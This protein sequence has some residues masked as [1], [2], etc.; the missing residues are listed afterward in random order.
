MR[1]CRPRSV[2]CRKELCAEMGRG[3]QSKGGSRGGEGSNHGTRM[4]LICRDREIGRW[5]DS[6]GSGGKPGGSVTESSGAEEGDD[7]GW[8]SCISVGTAEFDDQKC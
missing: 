7:R 4:E 5:L 3:R 1:R 2:T 8:M 6:G